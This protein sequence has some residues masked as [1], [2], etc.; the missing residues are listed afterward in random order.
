MQRKTLKPPKGHEELHDMAHGPTKGY[1][2]SDLAELRRFIALTADAVSML[3]KTFVFVSEPLSVEERREML[4]YLSAEL[5][6]LYFEIQLSRSFVPD[7]KAASD[8]AEAHA[9]LHRIAGTSQL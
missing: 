5:D 7:S 8:L 1:R 9:V 2:K 6:V 4:A 3:R